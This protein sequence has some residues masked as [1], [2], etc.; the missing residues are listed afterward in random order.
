MFRRSLPLLVVVACGC[1]P[2]PPVYTTPTAVSKLARIPIPPSATNVMCRTDLDDTGYLPAPDHAAWGRFDIPA[3]DLP[4]VLAAMPSDE[5]VKPYSGHSH[6]M[7]HQPA[8]AWWHPEQLRNPRMA[9]WGVM[10]P[11]CAV[12]L[13][14]GE[15]GSDGTL[16]VYFYSFE[17]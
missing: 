2:V 6:V 1:S 10:G 9:E 12:N 17:M 11:K 7:S 8:E 5:N 14:F 16:T 13:M 15:T 4:L 3:A